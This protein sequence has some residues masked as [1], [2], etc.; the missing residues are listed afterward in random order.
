MTVNPLLPVSVSIA[1]SAITVCAGTSVTFTATPVNG[2]TIPAY[3]WKVNG[4]SVT[5]ATNSTYAF[6]PVNGN[7]ITCLLTS[8]A[9][10]TTGNPA[11]SNTVTMT[12]NPLLP[13]SVSIAASAN[14]VCAGTS[15]TFTAP[16]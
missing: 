14:T 6:V 15:V 13:V 5:G 1:A 16:G 8:N 9:T 3:Q 7:T 11:T 2:G 4:T 10:C 12:V